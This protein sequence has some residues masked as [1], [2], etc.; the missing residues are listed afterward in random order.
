MI[1]KK[2]GDDASYF[3]SD[4][5]EC[6]ELIGRGFFVMT[7]TH[8]M[9]QQAPVQGMAWDDTESYYGYCK[10]AQHFQAASH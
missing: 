6:V 10:A 1:Y 5:N 3:H 4:Y 8:S 9:L 2:E 7:L